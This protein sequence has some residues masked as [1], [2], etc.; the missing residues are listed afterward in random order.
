ML[1]FVVTA[2]NVRATAY[3][4]DSKSLPAAGYSCCASCWQVLALKASLLG[5]VLATTL[6][7]IVVVSI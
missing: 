4:V 1:T 6:D 5:L 7:T 3:D 2:D